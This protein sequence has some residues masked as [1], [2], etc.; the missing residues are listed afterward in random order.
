[1]PTLCHKWSGPCGPLRITL[2]LLRGESGNIGP[3]VDLNEVGGRLL[4][5]T[6]NGR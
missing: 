1:M 4:H 2:S 3:V 6:L 5:M